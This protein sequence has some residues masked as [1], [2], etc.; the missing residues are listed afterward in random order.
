MEDLAGSFCRSHKQY[1]MYSF[2][3][4]YF[5]NLKL[6]FKC[7]LR[8]FA[9]SDHASDKHSESEP[10]VGSKYGCM[11]TIVNNRSVKTVLK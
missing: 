10:F 4:W 6:N 5:D 11:E 1:A 3:F 8:S 7:L 2:S 9:F